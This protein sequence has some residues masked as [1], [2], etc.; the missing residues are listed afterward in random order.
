VAA[1]ARVEEKLLP[2]SI[3]KRFA[4]DKAKEIEEAEGRRIGRR[5]M[6]EIQSKR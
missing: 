5:E 3:V 2:A 4:S 6:R 1:G